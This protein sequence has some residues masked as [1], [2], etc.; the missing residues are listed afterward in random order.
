MT[1]SFGGN[2][3][4]AEKYLINNKRTVRLLYKFFRGDNAHPG[5]GI[6]FPASLAQSAAQFPK[7]GAN[8]HVES[9]SLPILLSLMMEL[10][11][12]FPSK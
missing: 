7:Q 8:V 11:P 9:Q 10:N 4:K 2:I 1:F 6:L 12:H 5:L 3:R